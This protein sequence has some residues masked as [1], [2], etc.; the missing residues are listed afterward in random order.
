MVGLS[1]GERSVAEKVVNI[2]WT[3][4]V[5]DTRTY[6]VFRDGFPVTEGHLLF[7]PK[8]ETMDNLMACYKAAYAWGYGWTEDGYCDAYNI[9][10]NCGTAAG[11]TVMYPHV[12]LIPRRTG[13]M[14]DPRGGVRHVIPERGNYKKDENAIRDK[15]E[16]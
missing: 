5:L 11:Q 1:L 6:T 8:E 14:K 3:D 2:P 10:Q 12:H 7:V 9:G 16:K 4:V 15:Y 13:D